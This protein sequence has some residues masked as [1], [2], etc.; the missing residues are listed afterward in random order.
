MH[1]DVLRL[2]VRSSWLLLISKVG[3]KSGT[4]VTLAGFGVVL[5]TLEY[6]IM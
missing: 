5:P 6:C 3:R 4:D 1:R 2:F